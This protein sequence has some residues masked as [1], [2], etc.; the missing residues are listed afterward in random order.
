VAMAIIRFSPKMLSI[1]VL[2]GAVK[3]DQLR[4]KIN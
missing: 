2:K 4:G 3:Q 1:Y